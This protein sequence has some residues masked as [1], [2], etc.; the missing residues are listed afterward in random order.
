MNVM[1]SAWETAR[2]V[3]KGRFDF[4][5]PRR[6]DKLGYRQRKLLNLREYYLNQKTI[7]LRVTAERPAN[8]SGQ[9]VVTSVGHDGW[10]SPEASLG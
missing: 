4:M 1:I 3:D 9:I 10:T 7:F 6:G 2:R 8:R 5:L